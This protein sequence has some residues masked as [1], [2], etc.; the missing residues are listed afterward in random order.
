MSV[1][2]SDSIDPIRCIVEPLSSDKVQVLIACELSWFGSSDYCVLQDVLA[3]DE[4]LFVGIS[5]SLR[6]TATHPFSKELTTN[7][8]GTD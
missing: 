4:K 6:L 8:G 2:V 5:Y 3:G 7:V 1:L